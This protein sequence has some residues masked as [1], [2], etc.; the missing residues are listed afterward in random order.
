MAKGIMFKKSNEN[1]YAEELYKVGDIFITTNNENPSVRFGGTWELQKILTGGELI[2]FACV[3]ADNGV[4]K[5]DTAMNAE[6][7]F[8]DPNLGVK[9]YTV[10]N[11]IDNILEGTSGTILVHP[12][13]IVGLVEATFY[14]TGLGLSS[15]LLGYWWRYNRNTIP[16]GVTMLPD[17]TWGYLSTGPYSTNY[18]G[19]S[20]S[21]FYKVND[22]VTDD[23]FI[24]PILRPYNGSIRFSSADTKSH[25]LVKAYA[26][27]GNTKV[28]K[29]TA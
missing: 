7:S 29:R 20:N 11:Y 26:K 19:S 21:F 17:V 13:N 4:A 9:T 2:G 5:I 27:K 6:I 3:T 24:N 15:G 18:G 23:F 1:C 25:L 28:W 12:Q 16:S 8:S 10:E 22:G 14:I